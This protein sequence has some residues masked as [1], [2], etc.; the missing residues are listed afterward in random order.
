MVSLPSS[1]SVSPCWAGLARLVLLLRLQAER[2]RGHLG[3]HAALVGQL[4]PRVVAGRL[5]LVST[6]V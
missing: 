1:S 2:E 4:A 6:L 5:V 3:H